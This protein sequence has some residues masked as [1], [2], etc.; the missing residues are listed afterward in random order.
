ANHRRF[1]LFFCTQRIT[2]RNRG[3]FVETHGRASV[4]EKT[5]RNHEGLKGAI[6]TCWYG[7]GKITKSRKGKGQ[8]NHQITKR[9]GHK[10]T[11]AQNMILWYI[12]DQDH[13][14]C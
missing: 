12:W 2:K 4:Q 1:W 11:K 9:N 8:R 13:N 14:R 5:T 3:T 7:T 6:P 10:I